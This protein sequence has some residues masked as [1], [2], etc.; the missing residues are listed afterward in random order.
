[1]IDIEKSMKK[2]QNRSLKRK[3]ADVYTQAAFV[4]PACGGRVLATKAESHLAS[5]HPTLNKDDYV[6]LVRLALLEG[7]V[8]FELSGRHDST[9]NPTKLFAE[10]VKITKGGVRALYRG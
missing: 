8:K 10:A 1:M 2:S 9:T 7:K 5:K 6:E 3:T 4:C